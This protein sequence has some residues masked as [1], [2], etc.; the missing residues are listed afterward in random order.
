MGTMRGG[1]D[2]VPSDDDIFRALYPGLRRFAN[3]V[4]PA[5]MD[6]D[7]LVQEALS[8]TL[9]SH[10]LSELDDPGAYIRTVLI[11][12][13]SNQRRSLGRR[14]RAIARMTQPVPV[15]QTYPSDV[16]DLLRLAPKDRALLF[17]VT[18]EGRDYR[19]AAEV[20]GCTADAAR[21]RASRALRQLRI[22]LDEEN[23]ESRDA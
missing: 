20:L 5:E 3:V 2:E 16:S 17:M 19:D 9:A 14:R 22:E 1:A 15:A 4:R 6:A 7:D 23:R 11:R 18:V 12:V 10:E 21:A 8:R 13:A